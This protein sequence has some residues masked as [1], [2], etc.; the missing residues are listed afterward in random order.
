MSTSYEIRINECKCCNR[1]ESIE[2]GHTAYGWVF[3]LH[4][5]KDIKNFGELMFAIIRNG[6]FVYNEQGYK[7][8]I[9][10]FVDMI[11]ERR[12]NKHCKDYFDFTSGDVSI[13]IMDR[14]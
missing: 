3:C 2:I 6:G 5:S 7:I 4:T 9:D 14:G 10:A 12:Y 1:Y 8:S 13:D 11:V